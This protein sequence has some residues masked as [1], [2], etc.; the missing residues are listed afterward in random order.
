MSGLE[1]V[2]SEDL[3]GRLEWIREPWDDY[4]FGLKEFD[5]DFIKLVNQSDGLIVGGAVTF[6]GRDYNHQTG[7]RFELP[8]GL[9]SSI[10]KPVVFYGLSYRN[11]EG[12]EYHH[13][14]RLIQL[15]EKILETPNM[16]LSVRNDGTREWLQRTTGIEEDFLEVPDSA[17]FVETDQQ[18]NPR[19]LEPNSKNIILSFNDEDASFRF[20]RRNSGIPDA[21]DHVINQ[22][23]QAVERIADEF[24]VNFILVP[25]YFDDY[26]MI[27][28][29]MKRLRPRIGHQMTVSTGLSRAKDTGAFYERYRRVD[30]AVSMRVHS[31]SPCIGLGTPMVALITQERMRD[32]MERVDLENVCV[33]AFDKDSGELL[34]ERMSQSLN[35]PRSVT[36]QFGAVRDILR[37]QTRTFHRQIENLIGNQ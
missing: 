27:S 1:A 7:S 9:W 24:K 11:W 34:Y 18:T 21:R 5:S 29:F 32:F 26:Q 30:L 31:M 19:E 2:L 6:N 17:V 35:A 16:L 33:D 36:D 15:I 13:R 37:T 28:D 22:Y 14:D 8:F 23:V 3:P 10:R 20:S 4:T 25:H 12:Q